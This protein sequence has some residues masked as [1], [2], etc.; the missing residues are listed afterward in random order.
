M[1]TL[2]SNR[3]SAAT[4]PWLLATRATA[5]STSKSAKRGST[6]LVA[7][8]RLIQT[9][10]TTA[11]MTVASRTR[12]GHLPHLRPHPPLSTAP[13]MQSRIRATLGQRVGRESNVGRMTLRAVCLRCLHVRLCG[14]ARPQHRQTTCEA[15][16]SCQIS[17]CW[18]SKRV[19]SL[20]FFFFV[21]HKL[22]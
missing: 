14:A 12:Q 22:A 15:V 13:L 4:V 16:R 21:A 11:P 9:T 17:R 20:L 8:A 2:V 18:T 7:T 3:T 10:T 1:C 6:I 5:R 19:F